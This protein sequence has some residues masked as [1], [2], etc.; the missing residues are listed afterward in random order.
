MQLLI[1]E[2]NIRLLYVD[3]SRLYGDIRAEVRAECSVPE[4]QTAALRPVE[5][6]NIAILGSSTDYLVKGYTL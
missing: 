2:W 6:M 5:A 1:S 3:R 4:L